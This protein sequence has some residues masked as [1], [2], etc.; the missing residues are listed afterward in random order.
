MTARHSDYAVLTTVGRQHAW[1]ASTMSNGPVAAS[2]RAGPGG[3]AAMS[4]V[5]G[6]P[7]LADC[8]QRSCHCSCPYIHAW[9]HCCLAGKHRELPT[10]TCVCSSAGM[11]CGTPGQVCAMLDHE[12][13]NNSSV[14]VL[15]KSISGNT[16]YVM[17]NLV[18]YAVQ[19]M[20]QRCCS[21]NA[22]SNLHSCTTTT[23]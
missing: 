10:S 16:L 19:E 1:Q 18:L 11:A 17:T 9:V 21:R 6:L 15:K 14:H 3:M 7:T 2:H 8:Y 23:R 20:L 13:E 12:T 22:T 4:H 5:I